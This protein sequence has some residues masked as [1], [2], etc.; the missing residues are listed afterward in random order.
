MMDRL[1]I[2]NRVEETMI[3]S[4]TAKNQVRSVAIVS[5]MAQIYYTVPAGTELSLYL[6]SVDNHCFNNYFLSHKGA[7]EEGAA[8]RR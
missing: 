4:Q 3:I 7:C 8:Q 2:K 1:N 5:Q 6:C